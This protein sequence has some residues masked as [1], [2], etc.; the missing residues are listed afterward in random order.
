[1]AERPWRARKPE[2][3][4]RLLRNLAAAS[5]ALRMRPRLGALSSAGV[6]AERNL[7]RTSPRMRAQTGRRCTR[8]TVNEDYATI[9][10][11]SGVSVST[12]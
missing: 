3:L 4:Q 5:E 10:I 9:S 8:G 6:L 12:V 11:T 2:R 1:M 7:R